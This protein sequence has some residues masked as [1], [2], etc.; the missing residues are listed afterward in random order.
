MAELT[1][2]LIIILVLRH[3]RLHLDW[4][5]SIR[6]LDSISLLHNTQR[7]HSSLRCDQ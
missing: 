4:R 1:S 6:I 2:S 7:L 5:Y 3:F